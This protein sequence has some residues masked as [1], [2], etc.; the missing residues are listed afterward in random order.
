MPKVLMN[1]K[2]WTSGRTEWALFLLMFFSAASFQHPYEYDNTAS[3]YFL[4]S[5][6]ADFKRLDIT[7][8][9]GQSV[10]IAV[11]GDRIYSNKPPGLPFLAAPAYWAIRHWTS[12]KKAGPLSPM[13]CY[14]SRVWAVSLPF[15]LLGPIL[16]Q[17]LLAMG[18][19]TEDAFLAVIAYALGTI[20]WI[21]GSLFSGHAT[22][23]SLE[24]F[25]FAACWHLSHGGAGGSWRWFGAGLLAGLG[26]LCEYQAAYTAFVLVVYVL[27][28]VR[29]MRP[30]IFY[31]IGIS[32]CLAMMAAYNSACF[33]KPWSLAQA[34]PGPAFMEDL[35]GFLGV[36]WPSPWAMLALLFSPSRGLFFI[37]P[38]LLMTIPGLIRLKRQGPSWSAE[39]TTILLI[40]FGEWVINVG[41]YGWHAGWTFGPRYL[42]S[43]LPFFIV[44]MA[45]AL[46]RAWYI[47]LFLLSF[48]QVGLAEISMPNVPQ[49]IQNP[50]V[51]CLFPLFRYGYQADNLGTLLG[52]SGAWS[53]LPWLVVAAGLNYWG[54][55]QRDPSA[56]VARLD[57]ARGER[58]APGWVWLYGVACMGVLGG[59]IWVR[60]PRAGTVHGYNAKLLSDFYV[61]RSSP[62]VRAA[63]DEETRLHDA[64]KP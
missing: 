22:A 25:S 39:R 16:Y 32:A 41:Y 53:L 24:F 17:L 28:R 14:L 12:L 46:D 7:M 6:L 50:V 51:E 8:F 26:V 23:G 62:A 49:Y 19:G 2:L 36:G 27:W 18:V 31:S 43:T 60:S 13:A 20:A 38:I 58:P 48:A 30:R 33:G 45:F 57:R 47:P 29:D 1:R 44:P 34:N 42:T 63:M 15:A 10:D 56:L 59:L 37:M 35:H 21:H 54:W 64:A 4:M 52:L 3:R 40:V 61:E 11:H 9:S 55:P 5:A